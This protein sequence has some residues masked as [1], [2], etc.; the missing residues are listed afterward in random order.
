M[1][2]WP[3]VAL[4]VAALVSSCG[5][6]RPSG[7]V[8]PSP[9]PPPVAPGASSGPTRIVFVGA[10]PEPGSTLTGCGASIG[11]C[12][13][14]LRMSLDLFPSG[15]GPV[16]GS[17]AFLHATNKRACLI[18]RGG[19]FALQ[20]GQQRRLDVVFDESDACGTPVDIATMAVVVEGTIEV[21]S[22]QEWAVR[23]LFTP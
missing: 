11:G 7:P 22:R 6:D 17:V 12:E 14:R 1:S 20:A 21:A 5:S 10:S 9:S 19:P 3:T 4:A 2:R 16:L 13:G 15:T 23:Y 18:A 8:Q